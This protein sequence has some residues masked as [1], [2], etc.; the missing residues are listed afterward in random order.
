M[1]TTAME[2]QGVVF[3]RGDGAS[4][5][6]FTAVGQIVSF[7]GPGGS[8][9]VIDITTLDS[10]AKEKQMGLPDEGQFTLELILNADNAQHLALK[11]DRAN[12]TLRNF[13]LE[14]TD[15]SPATT[16][17][18]AG[19]VLGFQLSGGVDDVVRASVTIEISGPVTWA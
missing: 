6:V 16:L 3:K 14:L 13:K 7:Q 9:S 19:Y 1:T 5:E 15:A 4:P 8:A 10:T 17:S 18:F 11:T 12:R 2:A